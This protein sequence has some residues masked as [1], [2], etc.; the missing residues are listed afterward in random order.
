[1]LPASR[2][3]P[4]ALET[5]HEVITRRVGVDRLVD[6]EEQRNLQEQQIQID[7]HRSDGVQPDEKQRH[8]FLTLWLILMIIVHSFFG[9][10]PFLDKYARDMPAYFF[11]PLLAL[12]LLAVFKLICIV[13]LFKWKK[14]GFWIYCLLCI[15]TFAIDLYMVINSTG[16]DLSF[17]LIDLINIPLLYGVLHLGKRNKAWP[18][19]D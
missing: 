16:G 1:M 2:Y 5:A 7:V 12:A 6:L 14:W 17:P 15:T 8:W 11:R 10:V 13:A 3:T 4:F 19:L 18:Q 9:F